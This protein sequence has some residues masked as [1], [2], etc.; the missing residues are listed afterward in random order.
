MPTFEFT[1]PEG[2]TYSVN[3]PEGATAEQ[4]FQILQSQIGKPQESTGVAADVAKSA[5]VGIANGA[6]GLVGMPGD[7]GS[8]VSSATDY[9]GKKLGI[10]PESI[11]KFKNVA[12]SVARVLPVVNAT[13][14]PGSQDIQRGIEKYTGDFYQPQTVPGEYAK[15]A[16]EFLPALIGGPETIGTKLVTRVAAPAVVSE[17]AGQLS[18][19]T[20]AEPYARLGGAIVGGAAAT[21]GLN[22]LETAQ[23]AKQVTPTIADTKAAADVLY[24]N[25]T[26]AHVAQPI[27]QSTLDS[28]ANDITTRL[29]REG[30]RPSNAK[31][32]HDALAEIKTPATAGAPDVA[33]LAAARQSIKNLLGSSDA[34]KAGAF[35]ALPKIEAAIEAASPG[36]M[37]TLKEADKNWASMK[38]A[39]ALDKRMAR[40]D[41]RAAGEHS[42]ANVGN[43]VRQQV[44]SYLLSNEARYLPDA[45]KKELEKIVRGTASQNTVRFVANLLGGGGGLGML[46]GGTAGYEAGGIPGALAGAVAG[47]TLKHINNRSVVNQAQRVQQGILARSPLGQQIGSIMP[48]LKQVN[49][50]QIGLL[51]G[52][53]SMHPA[54]S[55]A[56]S[57]R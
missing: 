25:T 44:T 51:S 4:A 55:L 45:T 50:L 21:K 34:S 52:L 38:A 46:A 15:M 6:I 56:N 23:R 10:A 35:I 48:P 36:T 18:K 12:R 13:L 26:S 39:E 31:G 7:V 8:M 42:G 33:D 53:M 2:K 30:I 17:T 49:P 3:G 40:A 47:K 19:G 43:K 41:L 1:S 24:K 29:N 11:D 27:A 9:A 14:G 5:G 32:I 54:G 22:A 16:G 20:D 37:K 28:L 57:N